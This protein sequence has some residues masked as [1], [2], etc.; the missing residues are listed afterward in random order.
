MEY[1]PPVIQKEIISPLNE[2]YFGII[3]VNEK[4]KYSVSVAG[5]KEYLQPSEEAQMKLSTR[6]RLNGIYHE[7]RGTVRGFIGKI[8]SNRILGAKGNLERISGKLQY[9][10]GKFQGAIGL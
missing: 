1:I 9:R 10:V 3:T 4:P 5:H 7:V 6:F 8:G 2:P